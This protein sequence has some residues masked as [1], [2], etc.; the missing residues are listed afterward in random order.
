MPANN[1]GD[2][3]DFIKEQPIYLL[4]ETDPVRKWH[5]VVNELDP[6]E[7]DSG[8]ESSRSAFTPPKGRI[9]GRDFTWKRITRETLLSHVT[10]FDPVWRRVGLVCGA[11]LGKTTNLKWLE[12]AINSKACEVGKQFAFFRE[13][14]KL[15]ANGKVLLQEFVTR[16]TNKELGH[17]EA[18]IK[19]MLE[20]LR[21]A[22]RLTLLLDSLDQAGSHSDS[23]TVTALT[24]LLQPGNLWA[25]CPV[26]ISGRPFAFEQARQLF[27]NEEG[28]L[29]PWQFMRIGLL[30]EPEARFLLGMVDASPPALTQS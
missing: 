12:A 6:S 11:G 10:Q 3:S 26:W 30:D 14:R 19:A 16:V 27:H 4:T 7:Q 22:G 28:A 9:T 17:N 13:L 23:A 18:Q 29:Q 1:A 15:S 25:R 21:S 5:A 2:K 24:Q 8:S 20:R